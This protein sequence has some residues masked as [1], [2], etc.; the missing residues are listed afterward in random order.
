MEF[1]AIK[2]ASS[3]YD[4]TGMEL[5]N[6]IY[7]C[8]IQGKVKQSKMYRANPQYIQTGLVFEDYSTTPRLMDADRSA[9][10]MNVKIMNMKCGNLNQF[11]LTDSFNSPENTSLIRFNADKSIHTLLVF[12]YSQKGIEIDSV[13]ADTKGGGGTLINY[14][15]NAVKC[16]IKHCNFPRMYRRTILLFALPEAIDFYKKF[17]FQEEQPLNK[18]DLMRKL[19]NPSVSSDSSVSSKEMSELLRDVQQKSDS[20]VSSLSSSDSSLSESSAE[21]RELLRNVEE[22]CVVIHMD[23]ASETEKTD[24]DFQ[25]DIVEKGKQIAYNLRKPKKLRL[26]TR[27]RVKTMKTKTTKAKTATAK[28]TAKKTIKKTKG[29]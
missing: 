1:Y 8:I 29:K 12:G 3:L 18:N 23:D 20:E 6:R 11:F 17:G 14:L 22:K 21:L 25:Q 5:M 13:C 27:T 19:S 26:G 16:G 24:E 9:Y 4:P 2:K 7:D 15:I 10:E 28:T